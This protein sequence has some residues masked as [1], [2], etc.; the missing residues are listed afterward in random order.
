M[1][2]LAFHTAVLVVKPDRKKFEDMVAKLATLESY[3]GADQ[4]F[5]VSYYNNLDMAPYYDASQ[6]PSDLPMN[7]LYLGYSMNHIYWYEKRSWDHGYRIHQFKQHTIPAFVMTYPITPNLKPWY[8]WGYIWFD[9]H[10]VWNSVRNEIKE[11]WI[12]PIIVRTFFVI[13]MLV[14]SELLIW[15]SGENPAIQKLV[16]KGTYSIWIFGPII[17]FLSMFFAF[18]LVPYLIRPQYGIPMFFL[19]QN[20]LFYYYSNKLVH[21]FGRQSAT[22]SQLAYCVLAMAFVD[23]VMYSATSHAYSNPVFK[24]LAGFVTVLLFPIVETYILM[25]FTSSIKKTLPFEKLP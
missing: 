14:G 19:F 23:Y 24:G 7:R 4:G 12:F 13:G 21:I 15:K 11:E 18:H 17:S 20:I 1:N 8:W 16:P 6:G 10:W 3:D 25:K 22:L 5:L 9:L 2:I